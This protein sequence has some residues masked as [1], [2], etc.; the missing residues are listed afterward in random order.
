MPEPLL[1]VRNLKKYFPVRKGVLGR[2]R[3]YVHAV[4]DI[5]LEIHPGETLGL[6]GESGCGKTTAGRTILRLLEPTSGEILFEGT[7]LVQA[8]AEQLRKLRRQMQVVFQDPFSSLNPR[9]TVRAI[10]EEGL[11]IHRLGDRQQRLERVAEALRAVKLDPA[12]MDRYPHEF[13]GGQRQRICIARALVLQPKFIVLDE[14][15]AALDVSIQSQVINLLNQLK[16]EHHL[17][18][19]FISHD[20]AVVEYLSDRV[21]VMYLGQ[22]VEMAPSEELYHNPLHPYTQALLSAVPRMEPGQKRKRIVLP[23]DVPSPINPPS[24][25]RFH[26]RCPVAQDV[27]RMVPPRELR[28]PGEHTV[29]CHVVEQELGLSG[30]EA[31]AASSR[32]S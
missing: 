20:L 14:P 16:R 13:S 5:S 15:I 11:I 17:T 18:Y 22:I 31:Q 28:L 32:E 29:R 23:G 26:P 8:S 7:D 10:L 12:F 2:V 21:A 4:D 6:V 30:S 1:K 19:L 25:C 9:M 27:C 24:G 3:G